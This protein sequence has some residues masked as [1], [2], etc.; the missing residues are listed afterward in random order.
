MTP[1]R[2]FMLAVLVGLAAGACHTRRPSVVSQ[3]RSSGVTADST[4]VA[5]SASSVLRHSS[6]AA[7]SASSAIEFDSVCLTISARRLSLGGGAVLSQISE[8]A[9]IAADS[10]AATVVNTADVET[11]AAAAPQEKGR[12]GSRRIV[13]VLSGLGLLLFILLVRRPLLRLFSFRGVL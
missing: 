4:S 2:K 12:C 13:Y 10:A 5:S 3:A 8:S 11:E 7:L 9:G 6:G 1:G